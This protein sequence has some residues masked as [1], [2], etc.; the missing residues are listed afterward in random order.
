[1]FRYFKTKYHLHQVEFD[2]KSNTNSCL[3]HVN[4]ST[5]GARAPTAF[6]YVTRIGDI[7]VCQDN[8]GP[9]RAK[10][11]ETQ[12][13]ATQRTI[14]SAPAA[15]GPISRPLMRSNVIA[16]TPGS[17]IGLIIRKYSWMPY[18]IGLVELSHDFCYRTICTSNCVCA[19]EVARG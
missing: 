5:L 3:F 17:L 12:G 6:Q 19:S 13:N 1:M 16:I 2:F 18:I 14:L 11:D 4:P 15:L 9:R 10:S 8:N 7:P